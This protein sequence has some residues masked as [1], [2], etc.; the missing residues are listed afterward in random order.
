MGIWIQYGEVINAN[1]PSGA[2]PFAENSPPN[3]AVSVILI[4]LAVSSLLY[5]IRRSLRLTSA[6]LVT[7]YMALLVAAPLMTQGMW[8]RLFGLIVGLPQNQN[9]TH[10]EALPPMLWPHGA[11]LVDNGRFTKKL[12]GFTFTGTGTLGWETITWR[13]K[14]WSVPVI[15]N[16]DNTKAVS[17]L[18]VVL[19]RRDARNHELLVPGEPHMFTLLLKAAGFSSN[20]VCTVTMQADT[21]GGDTGLQEILLVQ[22]ADTEKKSLLFPDGYTRLGKT[23]IAAPRDLDQALTLAVTFSGPGTVGL[24]DIEFFNTKA[25]DGAY[26]GVKMVRQRDL[27]TLGP[28]ERDLTYVKPNNMV[29]FAGLRYLLT[30]F[31]P[32][33]Q[34]AMP[35]LAWGLLVGALFLGFFGFNVIM[36]KQWVENERFT[37]PMNIFPR[38]LFGEE[39]DGKGRRYLAIFRNKVMW[40][41]FAITLPLVLLKGLHFYYPSIPAPVWSNIW[42]APFLSNYV[43]DPAMKALLGHVSISLVF[44]LLA[45][46]LLVEKDILFSMWASFLVIQLTWLFGLI[47]NFN[48]FGADYPFFQ[49]QSVGGYI[50]YALIALFAARRHLK[51]VFLHLIGKQKVDDS[52]EVVSYRTAFICLVLSIAV[53][54]GWGLWTGAGIATSAIFFGFLL[55][56]GLA[57]SKIRAECGPA[58]G[59]WLPAGGMLFIAA[60]GGFAMFGVTGILIAT[61]VS[62]FTLATCFYFI[63]PAQVEMM[64]LGRHFKIWPRDISKGLLLGVVGGVVFGMVAIMVWTY[65]KGADNLKYTWPFSQYHNYYNYFLPMYSAADASY[66]QGTLHQIPETRPFDLVHNMNAKTIA[67]GAGVTGLLA[68]LRSAFVWFPFH[69]LGY[70]VATTPFGQV[71]WFTCFVAWL[72]RLVVLRIGGAHTV[73]TG[74]VPFAIGMFLACIV[75]IICFDVIGLYLR[76]VGVVDIYSSWP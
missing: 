25:M 73:R 32:W 6:E 74:L 8:H 46:M 31:I 26:S 38:N 21:E 64:E 37:F 48:R 52:Q 23:Q 70:L 60:A 57:A 1:S 11:N 49:Q 72:S 66:K 53:L 29:S 13:G 75:S 27:E 17:T 7:V 36:R 35:L 5:L 24:H 14:E 33:N 3:S 44:S 62:G 2:G 71:M 18:S 42:E 45:I 20:S 12:D 61:I 10:Y 65:G 22:S 16:G 54:L 34:W 67:I 56:V 76:S 40:I 58:F 59:Y 43:T 30:G 50:A 51:Q 69:P 15:D 9:Y 39:E 19:P 68:Y 4:L 63:A 55:L 41:G 47:F 28:N